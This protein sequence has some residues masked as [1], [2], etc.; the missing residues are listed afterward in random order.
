[1]SNKIGLRDGAPDREQSPLYQHR[2]TVRDHSYRSGSFG[3]NPGKLT[4]WEG[5]FPRASAC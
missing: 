2:V 3:D 4:D 1:M 5:Y